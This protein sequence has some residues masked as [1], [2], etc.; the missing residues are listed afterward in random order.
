MSAHTSVKLE[1]GHLRGQ[2]AALAG[3]F[4]SGY[5]VVTREEPCIEQ[6]ARRNPEAVVNRLMRLER[7]DDAEL[8]MDQYL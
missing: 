2:T 1:T 5:K 7:W 6:E 3:S 4:A 8:I